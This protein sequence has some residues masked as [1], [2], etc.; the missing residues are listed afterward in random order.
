MHSLSPQAGTSMS[1]SDDEP[2][3]RSS[4]YTQPQPI[5]AFEIFRH[6]EGGGLEFDQGIDQ[7]GVCLPWAGA[8]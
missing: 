5:P 6:D 1:T 3:G 2:R 4:D 8:G 7:A